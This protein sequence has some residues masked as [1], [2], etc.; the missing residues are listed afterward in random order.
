MVQ[1]GFGGLA[2]AVWQSLQAHFFGDD[3]NA[4]DLPL[5]GVDALVHVR[6]LAVDEA[7]HLVAHVFL[8]ARVLQLHHGVVGADE[9]EKIADLLAFLEIDDDALLA[10]AHARINIIILDQR[11][12]ILG[13][14]FALGDDLQMVAALGIGHRAAAQKHPTQIGAAQRV[15]GGQLCGDLRLKRQALAVDHAQRRKQRLHARL[16]RHV[17]DIEH[18]FLEPVAALDRHCRLHMEE[19]LEPGKRQPRHG[20]VFT[21]QLQADLAMRGDEDGAIHAHQPCQ[22]RHALAVIAE[23]QPQQLVFDIVGKTQWRPSSIS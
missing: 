12:Q 7:V 19:L 9:R 23:L 14:L 17:D 18:V 21:H 8:D 11:D 20:S 4:L 16:A 10:I 6:C 15:A 5:G 3:A 22:K 13:V 2:Q 1:S